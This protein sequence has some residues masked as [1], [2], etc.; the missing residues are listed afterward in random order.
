MKWYLLIIINCKRT[1]NLKIKN[2]D[3]IFDNFDNFL[4]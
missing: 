4:K 2:K 1:M 3:N